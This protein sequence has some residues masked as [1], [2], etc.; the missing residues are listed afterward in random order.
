MAVDGI[1]APRR[2]ASRLGVGRLWYRVKEVPS[3]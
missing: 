1:A 2:A 3:R